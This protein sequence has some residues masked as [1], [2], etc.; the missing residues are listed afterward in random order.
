ME[1]ASTQA[2]CTSGTSLTLRLTPTWRLVN[3]NVA[4]SFTIDGFGGPF[5][6]GVTGDPH[7]VVGVS[8]PLLRDLAGRLGI[9]WPDL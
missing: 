6:R 8:L 5:V 4:G 1:A 2:R 3:F 9:F 7:S